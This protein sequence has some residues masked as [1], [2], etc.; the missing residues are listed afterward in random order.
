M[1]QFLFDH[2]NVFASRFSF[3]WVIIL[4]LS[5]KYGSN[6][7]FLL[8][9]I[10]HFNFIIQHE[11]IN[12]SYTI[13]ISEIFMYNN[14]PIITLSR[15]ASYSSL[16]RMAESDR[17]YRRWEGSN[18]AACMEPVSGIRCTMQLPDRRS[19]Q[20]TDALYAHNATSNAPS[21]PC[22]YVSMFMRLFIMG[23]NAECPLV[24]AVRRDIIK[25]IYPY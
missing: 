9:E 12:L 11:N 13:T 3:F 21:V 7:H 23:H 1:F 14:N 17:L 18:P 4:V 25:E 22:N 15:A 16:H 19:W 2:W 5:S 24:Y 8:R 20:L 6:V 10:P